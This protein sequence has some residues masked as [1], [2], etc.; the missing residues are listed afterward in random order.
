MSE[1]EPLELAIPVG[2]A[3]EHL[4]TV[5]QF[6][7]DESSCEGLSNIHDLLDD[8]CLK[9]EDELLAVNY[10]EPAEEEDE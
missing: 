3:E 8:W 7:F 10:W 2:N 5:L 9:I 6:L 1:Q 4:V